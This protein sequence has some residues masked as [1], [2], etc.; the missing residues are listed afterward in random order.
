MFTL[1]FLYFG[2]NQESSLIIHQLINM[3]KTGKKVKVKRRQIKIPQN[4]NTQQQ[5]QI[6]EHKILN[7]ILHT[8]LSNAG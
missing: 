7:F 1:Y 5:Y 2:N 4:Q 8:F 6:H 3:N